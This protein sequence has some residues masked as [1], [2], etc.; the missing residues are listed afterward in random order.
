[1]QIISKQ[2]FDKLCS[3]NLNIGFYGGSFNP[4]HYGHYN[5]ILNSI[6]SL[7]LDCII[8]LVAYSSATKKYNKTAKQRADD[9]LIEI[10]KIIQKFSQIKPK[11][12]ISNIEEE[13]QYSY[14]YL[15]AKYISSKSNIKRYFIIG[16]DCLINLHKWEYCDIISFYMNLVVFDRPDWT[17]KAIKCQSIN[18][19]Y[20]FYKIKYNYVS[21]TDI[22]NFQSK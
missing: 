14:S 8:L 3:L 13:L 1:M 2:F 11:I 10:E 17:Y 5:I 12:Y 6:A 15:I 21:S 20:S 9:I 16:A 7:N 4:F 19:I 22:R 18:K